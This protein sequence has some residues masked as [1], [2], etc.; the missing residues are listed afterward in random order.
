MEKED[1]RRIGF[2]QIENI[3]GVDYKDEG[4]A[5]HTDIRELHIDHGSIRVEMFTILACMEGRLQVEKNGRSYNVRQNDVLICSPNDLLD[6][7]LISPDFEGAILCLSQSGILELISES[8]LWDRIFHLAQNPL[9]HV[10][11]EG[12]RH[13]NFYGQML[14]DNITL[15]RTPYRRQVIASI[16]RAA[17]Y[18]MLDLTSDGPAIP[19]GEGLIHQGEVLFK[20]FI[21]LLTEC[22]VKPRRVT[23]YASQLCI[24]PRYLS[25]VCKQVSGKT[26][27]EWINEYVLIDV[28]H[29][30]KNSDKSAKEIADL[31]GFPNLSFF[32]KYCRAHLGMSPLKYRRELRGKGSGEE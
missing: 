14:Q 23:W 31:L 21:K 9:L 12:A 16:I 11:E 7:C 2:D 1:I 17:L 5:F 30:L 15:P 8:D 3:R 13:I 6:N 24:T 18:E 10:S 28:R 19:H 25:F 27:L 32:G 4:F 22:S 29:W 20:G 26:A